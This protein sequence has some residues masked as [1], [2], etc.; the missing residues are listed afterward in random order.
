[1]RQL[2][3]VCESLISSNMTLLASAQAGFSRTIAMTILLSSDSEIFTFGPIFVNLIGKPPNKELAR[4]DEVRNRLA[5]YRNVSGA[6]SP[7]HRSSGKM[8]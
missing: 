6:P 8:A 5:V 7:R 1:M 4:P 2:A 3:S